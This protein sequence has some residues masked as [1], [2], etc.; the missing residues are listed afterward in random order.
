VIS[1]K[2]PSLIA[3]ALIAVAG[4]AIVTTQAGG[5]TAAPAAATL[6]PVVIHE[7]FTPLPCSGKPGRRTT[8][9][10]EGCAEQQIL[11]T[12]SQLNGLA[13]T[14]FPLLG[15]NAARRRFNAAQRA[16]LG[17]RR[18]DCASV[19]DEF[20][21]GSEAPVLAAQCDAARNSQRIR[22]LKAFDS[23]LS[24]RG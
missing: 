8:L 3:A 10:Q 1:T 17:Y 12:D 2:L 5:K 16:W 23:A 4:V 11:R 15:D 21:G 22:D 7:T 19:S 6:S 18:A 9:Q 20:E 14:I 24:H 13:K